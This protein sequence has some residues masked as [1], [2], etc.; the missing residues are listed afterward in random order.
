MYAQYFIKASDYAIYL[1][2]EDIDKLVKQETILGDLIYQTEDDIYKLPLSLKV[3]PDKEF[4]DLEDHGES[5]AYKRTDEKMELIIDMHFMEMYI[6]PMHKEN[7]DINC[8]L[9]YDSG[10]NK[11]EFYAGTGYSSH[12]FLIGIEDKTKRFDL[13]KERWKIH[14]ETKAKE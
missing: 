11:I 12:C 13:W 5:S 14:R 4:R 6:L 9:R 3:L 7:A 10:G 2:Q 1:T 8:N